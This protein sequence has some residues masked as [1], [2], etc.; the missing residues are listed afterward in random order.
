M[1][2]LSKFSDAL[3]ELLEIHDLNEKT[4]AEKTEIPVSCISLYTRGMQAPYLEAIVKLA[5]YFRCSTDY[6]L[7]LSD[8]YVEKTYRPCPPFAQRLN[9]LLKD[10]K[11]PIHYYYTDTGISKSSFYEW[12][13]GKSLPTLEKLVRLSEL[14]DYS[15]DK[16]LGRI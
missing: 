8:R 9:E 1:Y 7:G 12:K 13:R 11:Y 10:L 16:L 15:V 6:L 2:N 4:L 3:N 14:I 5:D